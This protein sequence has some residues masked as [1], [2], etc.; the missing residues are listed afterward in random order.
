V[1]EESDCQDLTSLFSNISQPVP[2]NPRLR[3]PQLLQS[4][5]ISTPQEAISQ[6]PRIPS[7]RGLKAASIYACIM[8]FLETRLGIL[9]KIID[10]LGLSL[11]LQRYPRDPEP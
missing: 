10:D 2:Q 6:K 9:S 8:G 1:V 11:A 7:P 3:N 5:H 4:P